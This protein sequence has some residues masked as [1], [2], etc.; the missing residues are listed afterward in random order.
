MQYRSLRRFLT[1][2]AACVVSLCAAAYL[3]FEA[4]SQQEGASGQIAL[5]TGD[6]DTPRSEAAGAVD[7]APVATIGPPSASQASA[8]KAAAAD[9]AA[10]DASL[11]RVSLHPNSDPDLPLA[12]AYGAADAKLDLRSSSPASDPAPEATLPEAAPPAQAAQPK[13]AA[14]PAET[15]QPQNTGQ[16]EIAVAPQQAAIAPLPPLPPASFGPGKAVPLPPVR[17]AS[18]SAAVT[19]PAPVN[20]AVVAVPVVDPAASAAA[21]AALAPSAASQVPVPVPRVSKRG[22]RR[23]MGFRLSATLWRR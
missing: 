17:P 8:V 9:S 20:A 19:P 12:L 11:L 13:S 23:P 2:F 7:P 10:G 1:L 6:S 14:Q 15:A 5:A 16:L 3:S 18:L 4:A 21:H 22:W